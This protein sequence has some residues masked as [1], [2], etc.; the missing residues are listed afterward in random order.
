MIGQTR[1]AL[2]KQ[3][4]AE[5]TRQPLV[6]HSELLNLPVVNEIR[7]PA[8]HINEIDIAL[9]DNLI[10]DRDT[11]VTHVADRT[12]HQRILTDLSHASNAGLRA[13]VRVTFPNA[14]SGEG[15]HV[16]RG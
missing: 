12:L 11:T 1:A 8:G 7:H 14:G 13:T 9:T 6:E 4:E 5:R 16:M 2:V 10:G 3:N 15:L